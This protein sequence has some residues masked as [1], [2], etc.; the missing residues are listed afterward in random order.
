M[1]VFRTH[2]MGNLMKLITKKEISSF[3]Q[4]VKQAL[5]NESL[6]SMAQDRLVYYVLITDRKCSKDIIDQYTIIMPSG[7][8][9]KTN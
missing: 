1:A 2:F 8:R 9:I 3:I 7:N 4:I 6:I 5:E